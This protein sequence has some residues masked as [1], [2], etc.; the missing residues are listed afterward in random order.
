M[1]SSNN[2]PSE[3]IN[4]LAPY[5]F[6]VFPILCETGLRRAENQDFA[7]FDHSL[8]IYIIADGM[9]GRNA[10]AH[11]SKTAASDLLN[12]IKANIRCLSPNSFQTMIQKIN[13]AMYKGSQQEEFKGMG[14]TLDAILLR[15]RQLII[16]H[17]GDSRV[18]FLHG[19]G[20][21]E[22]ATEDQTYAYHLFKKGTIPDEE[23]TY[24]SDH[25]T[26]LLNYI[27]KDYLSMPVMR[28][29]QTEGI[30]KI[31]MVT[32]GVTDTVTESELRDILLHHNGNEA[33]AAIKDRILH[34]KGMIELYARVA[35]W[36]PTSDVLNELPGS[37]NY[38]A[39]L[40]ERRNTHV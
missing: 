18:Y 39:L 11:A 38:T 25:R 36:K 28:M 19:D 20:T 40:L 9:G 29:F 27:G 12:E 5:G 33:L 21:L 17:A 30:Q 8:G 7:I 26:T 4:R 32:D 35:P 22:R 13:M 3:E 23:Q 10:G 37:D 31:L 1:T 16:G 24:V 6:D 14:T 34:P 15:N 2:P